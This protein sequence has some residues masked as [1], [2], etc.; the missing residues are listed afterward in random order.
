MKKYGFSGYK[1][2]M[3]ETISGFFDRQDES[4]FPE[5]GLL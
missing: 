2:I 5:A 4:I 3:D 1:I